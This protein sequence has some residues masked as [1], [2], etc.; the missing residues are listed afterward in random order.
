KDLP[1]AQG[2]SRVRRQM[3]GEL[4]ARILCGNTAPLF[5]S[6]YQDRLVTRGFESSYTLLPDAA[7]ALMGGESKDPYAVRDC[8]A[9]Q[10]RLYA[11]HGIEDAL[12]DRMKK[13]CY[14][15]NV[16]VLDQPDELCR[17]QAESSFANECCLNF[18]QLYDTITKQEIQQ[19]FVRW[20]QPDRMTLSVV[21]PAETK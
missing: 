6:L 14:G 18:A 7:A 2:E 9:E 21:L 4:A 15:L 5:V 20:A 3:V 17:A 11:A 16:R 1:L 10:V 8:V 12:F 13:A 19:M